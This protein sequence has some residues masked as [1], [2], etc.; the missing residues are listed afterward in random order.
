MKPAASHHD[1][2]ATLQAGVQALGLDLSS[3]QQQ[4]LATSNL[5][6]NTLQN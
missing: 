2:A 5:K 1:L 4:S 6:C 3:A